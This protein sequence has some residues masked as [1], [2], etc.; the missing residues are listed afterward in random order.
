MVWYPYK[1]R[2]NVDVEELLGKIIVNIELRDDGEDDYIIFTTS[3]D[4]KYV[5]FHDQN[6][7]ESV[8]IEDISGDLNDLIGTPILMAEEISED[9]SINDEYSYESSTWTFYKF[10]TIKGYVTIRWYGY[11][12]GYYSESVDFIRLLNQDN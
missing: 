11:S 6:C 8:S 2:F 7:C 10:A 12:N 1:D 5:M 3:E 9:G 4:D